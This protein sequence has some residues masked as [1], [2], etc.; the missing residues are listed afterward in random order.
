MKKKDFS[1]RNQKIVL[2]GHVTESYGPMQ[3][4]PDYLLKN[5]DLFGVISHPFSYCTIP[6]SKFYLYKKK[7]LKVEISGPK[8][9]FKSLFFIQYF[10]DVL[11]TFYFL[12]RAHG[13]WDIFIGCDCLNA[14]CGILL[15][16]LKIVRKVV[17]YE[18]EYKVR[19]FESVILNSFFQFF[20][21]FTARRADVVWDSPPGLESLRES[22][23]VMP[24]R[25]IKVPHGVDLEKIKI[26]RRPFDRYKLV[27]V[28]HV[29]ASK[30]LQLVT[31]ALEEVVKTVPLVKMAI[32]GSGPFEPELKKMVEEKKLTDN[33]I[34]W[35]FTDH[36]WTLDYLPKCAMGIAP[37]V[38]LDKQAL[39]FAEPL[40]VK[41]Y[42]AC[43]LPVIITS[44]AQLNT[45]IRENQ[46]GAVVDYEK[47]QMVE[48]MLKLLTDDKFYYQCRKNVLSYKGK[49]S[50]KETFNQAF[51]KTLQITK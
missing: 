23:S 21:G 46:M 17:F 22:Q 51:A 45:N 42:L 9:K 19:R 3:A 27:Y 20:N 32:I 38:S 28:G 12:I 8:Y 40:K 11:L 1:I 30:G 13:R 41:D 37:Y 18:N 6:C 31:S 33:F 10:S 2:V 49:I 47:N 16:K 44:F 29:T 15:K 48:A 36:D 39:M 14:F 35:G 50:W 26:P 4:L 25:I 34:F 7:K 43:G 24:E 5:C